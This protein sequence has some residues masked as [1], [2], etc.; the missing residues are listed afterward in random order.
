M[1]KFDYFTSRIRRGKKSSLSENSRQTLRL[2]SYILSMIKMKIRFV[3]KKKKKKK[4]VTVLPPNALCLS[5]R[6]TV[7]EMSVLY[8]KDR[9]M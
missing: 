4:N 3:K 2:K 5:E 1:Q 9:N 7:S 6:K 8:K